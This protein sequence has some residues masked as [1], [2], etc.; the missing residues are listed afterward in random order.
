MR[1]DWINAQYGIEGGHGS[2]FRFDP[3]LHVWIY[4]TL[5]AD[6]TGEAER[7]EG[8]SGC[9]FHRRR[10]SAARSPTFLPTG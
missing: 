6:P 10:W 1:H 7:F 5:A 8:M 4:E 2:A 3:R 9:M